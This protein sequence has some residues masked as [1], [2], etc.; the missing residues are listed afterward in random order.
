MSKDRIERREVLA[1]ISVPLA[2]AAVV[3]ALALLSPVVAVQKP[4]GALKVHGRDVTSENWAARFSLADSGGRKLTLEDEKGRFVLLTFGYTHCPDACPATLARLA[5]VRRFLDKDAQDVQVLF[6]TIDPERDTGPF[7]ERYVRTFDPTF[8]GLRG[9]DDEIDEAAT[10][11]HADYQIGKYEG[12]VLVEHTVD[13]YLV[14][15]DGRVRVVLPFSLSARQVVEDV[16]TVM[17]AGAGC[18][19]RSAGLDRSR[20]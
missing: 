20:M 4:T 16:R 14:D 10:S 19:P 7:L 18:R 15:R 1:A 6:V 2:M 12:Q 8:I 17:A 3:A 11:F 13:T 5:Q 9:T